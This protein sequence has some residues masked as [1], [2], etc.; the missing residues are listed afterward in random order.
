M[1]T[2]VYYDMWVCAHTSLY[3]CVHVCYVGGG[4]DDVCALYNQTEGRNL[5][6]PTYWGRGGGGDYQ[7]AC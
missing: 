1:Y 5:E 4:G 7:H 6:A 2:C 3:L